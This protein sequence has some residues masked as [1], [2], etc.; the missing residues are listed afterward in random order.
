M[1]IYFIFRF[2][3]VDDE[4]VSVITDIE[5]DGPTYTGYYYAVLPIDAHGSGYQPMAMISN[6]KAAKLSGRCIKVQQRS[7][8]LEVFC[9]YMAQKLCQASN[10]RYW[11]CN[12]YDVEVVDLDPISGDIICVAVVLVKATTVTKRVS[13]QRRYS[14]SSMQRHKY[15]ACFKFCWN[16]DS[17]QCT[18]IDSE[19]LKELSAF[20]DSSQDSGGLWHPARSLSL[21]LQKTW[22]VTTTGIANAIKAFT[23]DPVLRGDSLKTIVDADH[24]VALINNELK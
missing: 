16:L 7:L 5:D 1:I 2:I 21:S 20:A 13:H 15:E 23:N 24:L 14:I 11:F 18:V 3:E 22:G 10:M 19:P 12:D 9:H 8:D 17:G 6:S 4:M